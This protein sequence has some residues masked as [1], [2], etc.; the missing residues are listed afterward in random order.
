MPV[1]REYR[2]ADGSTKEIVD[3]DY[4]QRYRAH[5]MD[6]NHAPNWRNDPTYHMSKK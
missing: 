5:L 6:T 4:E 1:L 2:M 3:P